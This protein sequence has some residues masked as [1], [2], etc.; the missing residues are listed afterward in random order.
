MCSLQPLPLTFAPISQTPTSTVSTNNQTGTADTGRI[1]D[2]ANLPSNRAPATSAGNGIRRA[3]QP[4]MPTAPQNPGRLAYLDEIRRRNVGT[5]PFSSRAVDRLGLSNSGIGL[6]GFASAISSGPRRVPGGLHGTIGAPRGLGDSSFRRARTVAS[7][8]A[9]R[10][11]LVEGMFEIAIS[12]N[13]SIG[14][15]LNATQLQPLQ[16]GSLKN[17]TSQCTGSKLLMQ[18]HRNGFR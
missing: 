4:M 12:G 1:P 17:H 13:L 14:A 9:A 18:P 15:D 2:P 7:E 3:P 6:G 16:G 5:Q 10:G 8:R 11:A